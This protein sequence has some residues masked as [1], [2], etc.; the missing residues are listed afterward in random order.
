M[1]SAASITLGRFAFLPV[2]EVY[3]VGA[4]PFWM[5]GL[6][7][8]GTQGIPAVVVPHWDNAEGGTHDTSRCWLGALVFHRP[9]PPS[10]PRNGGARGLHE[11]T[12]VGFDFAALTASK[13]RGRGRSP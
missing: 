12:A 13:W 11:H 6:D 9:R 8:L 2:Y 10:P 4:D 7:L 3:K 5:E 1:A